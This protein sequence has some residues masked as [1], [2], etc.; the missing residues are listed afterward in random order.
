MV[1][2][3]QQ[4]STSAA[5]PMVAWQH[6]SRISSSPRGMSSPG[7]HANKRSADKRAVSLSDRAVA[8][9][10]S[11]SHCDAMQSLSIAPIFAT[12]AQEKR[13]YTVQDSDSG[14]MHFWPERRA[15]TGQAGAGWLHN[16][17]AGL[18]RSE[19]G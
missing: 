2:M 6:G 7:T 3:A 15:Q 18:Q 9:S 16:A 19:E 14:N 12:W 17:R 4:L 1:W 11:D 13:S 5:H 8:R 10:G